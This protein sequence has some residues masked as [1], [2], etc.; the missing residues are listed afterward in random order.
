MSTEPRQLVLE[1]PLARA[2][3]IDNFF[4]SQSNR[5]A[6]E[7]IERWPDWPHWAGVL[8]GPEGSGKSHLAHV[9]QER[10]AAHACQGSALGETAVAAFDERP[11]ML[12]ED[13]DRGIGDE[14]IFFHLL[15]LARERKGSIL[16]TSRQAPGELSVTLPDLR[17]R[18]RAL[19]LACI[20]P[21]DEA[22]LKAVLIKLFADR[23]L[24][25]EPHVVSYIALRIER[26]MAAANAIVEQIDRRALAMQRSVTRALAAAVLHDTT[27]ESDT[28][29]EVEDN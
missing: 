17:S 14:R 6:V 28:G 5:A 23:Q 11:T 19:P 2:L 15:N 20:A 21:P 3:D 10:A 16:V 26:S 13:I 27:P 25:I 8:V 7:L 4:V 12:I 29:D 24:A 18:L 1:L 9:W 22:L